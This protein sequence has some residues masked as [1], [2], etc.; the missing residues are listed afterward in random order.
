MRGLPGFAHASSARWKHARDGQFGRLFSSNLAEDVMGI[1]VHI[2]EGR[3]Q[4]SLALLA[5][6]SS[7]LAGL[8]V[9]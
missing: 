2:R 3:F 4:R 6:L 9:A 5:G 1:D 8:E 7:L